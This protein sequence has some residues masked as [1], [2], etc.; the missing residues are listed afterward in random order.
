M[1][2]FHG[3]RRFAFAA[4]LVLGLALAS[5][6]A[7]AGD[8]LIDSAK[9]SGF[10]GERVDG[11]LGLVVDDVDAAIRRKVN[12]INAGRRALYEQTARQTSTTVEQV[13]IVTG[14]KLVSETPSGQYVMNAQGQWVKK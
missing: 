6:A 5:P 11:Y 3:I 10:V 9:A 7:L 8:P 4:L 14:E 1:T 12:E 13:G 2:L